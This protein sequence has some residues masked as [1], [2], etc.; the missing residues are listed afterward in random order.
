MNIIFSRDLGLNAI[1]EING[2]PFRNLDKLQDLLLDRNQLKYLSEE[3]FTGLQNL[4][5]L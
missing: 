4:Q 5:I 3:T 1:T 2:A